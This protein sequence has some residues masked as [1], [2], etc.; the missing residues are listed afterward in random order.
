M[1]GGTSKQDGGGGS[2]LPWEA[3]SDMLS[4][5]RLAVRYV[6]TRALRRADLTRSYYRWE[7][8]KTSSMQS[9]GEGHNE[10]QGGGPRRRWGAARSDE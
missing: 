1:L 9:S 4:K 2:R 5:G 10:K 6:R 8:G 3:P 7:T